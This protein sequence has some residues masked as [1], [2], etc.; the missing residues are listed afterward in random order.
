VE[1]GDVILY[2]GE[3]IVVEVEKD[4]YI[5]WS[6]DVQPDRLSHT[7]WVHI[8]Q[9]VMESDDT[10]TAASII[11]AAKVRHDAVDSIFTK[12]VTTPWSR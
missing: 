4:G 12:K 7:E 11:R 9:R 1:A 6:F 3:W 2:I 8:R 5:C 10:F